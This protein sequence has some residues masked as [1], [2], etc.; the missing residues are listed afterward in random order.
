M[1]ISSISTRRKKR[2]I[3]TNPH[4]C[5]IFEKIFW[6]NV[7]IFHIL[8]PLPNLNGQCRKICSVP[9]CQA[10]GDAQSNAHD[11]TAASPQAIG[12]IGRSAKLL[13]PLAT[14]QACPRT[15]RDADR[16]VYQPD[17][18]SMRFLWHVAFLQD[19]QAV[20]WSLSIAISQE[21]IAC[22][23]WLSVR[24]QPVTR[25]ARWLFIMTDT[26]DGLVILSGLLVDKE[27]RSV[28]YLPKG[29]ALRLFSHRKRIM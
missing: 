23:Q 27:E 17:S 11:H 2:K 12:S 19:I 26:M 8:L 18:A 28:Q 9:G 3:K 5:T 21:R 6:Q 10:G 29:V 25:L 22:R 7:R 1:P 4:I 15:V 24:D 20:Y 16:F 13:Y 14:D